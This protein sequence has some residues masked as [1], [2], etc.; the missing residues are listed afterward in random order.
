MSQQH[1]FT[2]VTTTTDEK[3]PFHFHTVAS[4]EREAEKKFRR[5][6]RHWRKP[7]EVKRA[8]PSREKKEKK[9]K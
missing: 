7:L 1:A 4:S 5:I 2:V 3:R 9:K 8:F 6:H